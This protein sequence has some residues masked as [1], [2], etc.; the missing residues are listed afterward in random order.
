[1]MHRAGHLHPNKRTG[2]PNVP[3][4]W[5]VNSVP[6]ATALSTGDEGGSAEGENH[7]DAVTLRIGDGGQS[8]CTGVHRLCFGA[9][10]GR[11]STVRVSPGQPAAPG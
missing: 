8:T 10:A 3:R 7:P 2:K 4:G 11:S 5:I 9:T 6:F 1:M